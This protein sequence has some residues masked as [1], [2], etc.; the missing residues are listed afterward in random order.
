MSR[1]LTSLPVIERCLSL[2]R[3]NFP[4]REGQVAARMLYGLSTEGIALDLGISADTVVC[5]RRRFYQRFG[6]GG[7]RD[8]VIW[9]MD[10]YGTVG[11]Y[12]EPN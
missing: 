5:Y 10:L 4:K 9:Y 12:L 6:I 1:A 3:E 8:L 7:F 11:H 2:C